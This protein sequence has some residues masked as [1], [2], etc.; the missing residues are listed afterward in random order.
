[1]HHSSSACH[2]I[3]SCIEN[4]MAGLL[5]WLCVVALGCGATQGFVAP[6][7]A[8]KLPATCPVVIL[9]GF[10][11][12]ARDCEF[13]PTNPHSSVLA[14]CTAYPN[15]STRVLAPE[16]VLLS[17]VSIGSLAGRPM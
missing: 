7:M 12:D 16:C 13:F 5:L 8:L 10:G 4:R 17:L 3:M 6:S 14:L 9:P 11:N 15:G 1:M 2:I